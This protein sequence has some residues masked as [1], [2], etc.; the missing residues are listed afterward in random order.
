MIISDSKYSEEKTPKWA[1]WKQFKY[2]SFED[3]IY[4]SLDLNP[5]MMPWM[6]QEACDFYCQEIDERTEVAYNWADS[7]DW[8][9]GDID[10]IPSRDKVD[11]IG[12]AS[13][14]CKK[15]KW[16]VPEEFFKVSG[17]DQEAVTQA[18]NS[19]KAVNPKEL[20]NHVKLIGALYDI[21]IQKGLYR[22]DDELKAYLEAEYDHL[23]GF[24]RRT[25]DSRISAAKKAIHFKD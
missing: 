9:C 6:L 13:W 25:L 3:A 2:V 10:E 23:G 14:V 11:L 1:Y 5:H 8:Y 21:I 24:S 16:E 22:T 20:A 17:F 7:L 19:E 12:F 18:E 4:L 15:M